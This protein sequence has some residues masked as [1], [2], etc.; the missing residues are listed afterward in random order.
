MAKLESNILK[1]IAENNGF[2]PVKDL[3]DEHMYGLNF[4][5]VTE[6]IFKLERIGMC[7]REQYKDFYDVEK[8]ML[9]VTAKGVIALNN[10][11]VFGDV[12]SKTY[13]QFL[14]NRSTIQEYYDER[15]KERIIRN[16]RYSGTYR[17]DY[18]NYLHK[19]CEKIYID[20]TENDGYGYGEWTSALP[21]LPGKSFEVDVIFR[22]ITGLDNKSLYNNVCGLIEFD[23][24]DITMDEAEKAMEIE[25]RYVATYV[26]C[27]DSELGE[28]SEKIKMWNSKITAKINSDKKKAF[29][30]ASNEEKK[31]YMEGVDEAAFFDENIDYFLDKRNA[32]VEGKYPSEWFSLDEIKVF[33][34]E[35]FRSAESPKEKEIDRL[36][37]EINTLDPSS[38]EYYSCSWAWHNAGIEDL[39]KSYYNLPGS[40]YGPF[41]EE[42]GGDE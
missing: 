29:D 2:I 1:Q 25:G 15:K 19:R 34:K 20:E 14:E 23:R 26:P 11:S 41:E 30:R 3:I 21:M 42:Q 4:Q 18:I 38:L 32:F 9:F 22:M 16:M 28:I 6:E 39:I 10:L 13:E 36:L 8:D 17:I 12:T 5:T 27:P 24:M 33:I 31:I 37:A 7:V 35:N 40:S